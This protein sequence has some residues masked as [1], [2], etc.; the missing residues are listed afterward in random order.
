MRTFLLAIYLTVFVTAANAQ[1]KSATIGVN[2]LTCSM[3]QKSVEKSLY[4][5]KFIE[6][7]ETDLESTT[8][9]VTFKPGTDVV[10]SQLAQKVKSAGFSVR[11]LDAVFHFE[12]Y[13][14][15]GDAAFTYSNSSYH[16]LDV[17]NKTLNGDKA[18]RFI[19]SEYMTKDEYKKYSSSIS[20]PFNAFAPVYYV[21]LPQ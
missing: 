11:N 20:A 15:N 18:I 10:I 14:A 7:I 2:G 16:F 6:N 4:R 3:C 13:T 12:N 5:L 8:L 19:G 17:N 21:T 1:F 9:N